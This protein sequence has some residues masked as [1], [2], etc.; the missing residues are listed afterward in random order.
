MMDEAR[1]PGPIESGWTDA[2]YGKPRRNGQTPAYYRSYKD[3]L[4]CRQRKL[5]ID[6]DRQEQLHR[7]RGRSET[8]DITLGHS[9]TGRINTQ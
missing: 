9:R 8:D 3:G 4:A 6:R 1:D 2:F 5:D 7:Y